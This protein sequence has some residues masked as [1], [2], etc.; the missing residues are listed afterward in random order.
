MQ[1]A[2]A[3][4]SSLRVAYTYTDSVS[5]TPTVGDDF[6]GSLGLSDHM[7]TLT[8]TQWI[9]RRVNL[10]F[11]LFAVSDYYLSPYGAGGRQMICTGPVKA[12]LVM[13]YDLPTGGDLRLDLYAKVDN[14][15]N[16]FYYEDGFLGPGR[17]AIG[18]MPFRY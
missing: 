3:A 18:G 7:F 13:R 4:S 8:A 14:L 2:P 17:W 9:A 12:D 15:F 11:D 16:N 5:E 10:A 1:A 6:Y